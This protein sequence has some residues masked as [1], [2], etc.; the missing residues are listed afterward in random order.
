VVGPLLRGDIAFLGPAISVLVVLAMPS[1]LAGA[2]AGVAGVDPAARDAAL[3][4]G[5]SSAELLVRVEIPCALPLA[6][7]GVRSAALQVIATAT[8]AATASVGGLGRF[9]ID[10][11]AVRD[12]AQMA[13]GALLV[14]ALAVAVDGVFALVQSLIVSPGLRAPASSRHPRR[15]FLVPSRLRRSTS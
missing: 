13:G 12:Y 4:M 9:L 15:T 3:G 1:I 11:L 8:V 10:G 5:M 6:F 14:A 2:Y 7:S